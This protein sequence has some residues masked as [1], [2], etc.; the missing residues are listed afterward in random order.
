M[1]ATTVLFVDDDASVLTSFRRIL[2]NEPYDLVTTDNPTEALAIL[3]RRKIALLITDQRMPVLSG[4]ALVQAARELSPHT[5]IAILSAWPGELVTEAAN[6][7]R[8]PWLI[9]KPCDG[10][11]VRKIIRELIDEHRRRGGGEEP[12]HEDVY[13]WLHAPSAS[14]QTLLPALASGRTAR[15]HLIVV[16]DELG[17]DET[18]RRAVR[19][20][21]REFG[22]EAYLL[23]EH[24]ADTGRAGLDSPLGSRAR[25]LLLAQQNPPTAQVL[26]RLLARAG[27]TFETAPDPET[28][29]E[30]LRSGTFDAVCFVLGDRP[31][32]L[33]ARLLT[34]TGRIPVFVCLLSTRTESAICLRVRSCRSLPGSR[35]IGRF[36]HS[37]GGLRPWN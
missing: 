36:L 16:P 33:D 11:T 19:A 1:H 6:W 9:R 24:A 17:P 21:C 27:H 12:D 32:L 35:C 5:V 14:V 31:P 3:R 37:S 29:L 7:G 15:A 4:T 30:H 23:D 25:H 8:I 22:Y 20:L 26:R 34:C 2:R 10:G 13:L 18:A 28:A